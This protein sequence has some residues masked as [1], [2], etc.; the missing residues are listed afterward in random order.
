MQNN[1]NASSPNNAPYSPV[2]PV[3]GELISTSQEYSHGITEGD[4]SDRALPLDM[5]RGS[6]SSSD[7]GF[8]IVKDREKLEKLQTQ[9]QKLEKELRD[10]K[11]KNRGFSVLS[12]C[13]QEEQAENKKLRAQNAKLKSHILKLQRHLQSTGGSEQVSLLSFSDSNSAFD[14][15]PS[16]PSQSQEAFDKLVRDN[17]SLK[18]KVRSMEM[19]TSSSPNQH[20][21]EA[22]LERTVQALQAQVSS[23]QEQLTREQTAHNAEVQSLRQ[24]IQALH[25]GRSSPAGGAGSTEERAGLQRKVRELTDTLQRFS[26]SLGVQD[27]GTPVLAGQQTMDQGSMQKMSL[28]QTMS[29]GSKH[30]NEA[31]MNEIYRLNDRLKEL[32]TM[33][34]RWQEHS[35]LREEFVEG[36]QKKLKEMEG[37]LL[38]ARKVQISEEQQKRM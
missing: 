38:E 30:D 11:F 20:G 6:D 5:S 15:L 26:Q 27:G 22:D 4:P 10:E 34:T 37:K 9:I 16:I 8:V 21:R 14:S 25:S 29:S 12:Q 36:L 3:F 1:G 24:Q 7:D 17:A 31:L 32:V 18:Q 13:T 19:D 35:T 33:N 28:A 2:V 23:L